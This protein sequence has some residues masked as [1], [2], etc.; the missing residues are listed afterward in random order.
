MHLA[1][2]HTDT[3]TLTDIAVKSGH[4]CVRHVFMCLTFTYLY[5]HTLTAKGVSGKRSVT[6][7]IKYVHSLKL[8]LDCNLHQKHFVFYLLFRRFRVSEQKPV[9]NSKLLST[10]Y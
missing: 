6:D 7:S 10:M 8:L 3:R 9:L 4:P 1:L 2:T 5:I